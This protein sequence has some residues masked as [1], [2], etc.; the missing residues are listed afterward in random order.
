MDKE[1]SFEFIRETLRSTLFHSKPLAERT[2][3]LNDIAA[4]EGVTKQEL[5]ILINDSLAEQYEQRKQEHEFRDVLPILEQFDYNTFLSFI[6]AGDIKGKDLLALCN[7][8]KKFQNYC[9]QG[10]EVENKDGDVIRIDDQ[11]LFR[12][13]L[14]KMR[15]R[16]R[17]GKTPRETYIER[18]IGGKVW[19]AGQN[20]VGTLGLGDNQRRNVLTPVPIENNIIEISAGENHSLCLDNKGYVWSFGYGME[21]Q[22]GTRLNRSR[23]FPEYIYGLENIVQVS[24]GDRHSLCLDNQGRVWSFGDNG[25][26][27]LGLGE[28]VVG[29]HQDSN[30]PTL[31]PNLNNIIQVSAGGYHSLCLDYQGRVWG[32]GDNR[33]GE[34]GLGDKKKRVLP[35]LI[36][37][38][39]NIIQVSAGGYHSLCLDNQGRVWSF[40]GNS[41]GQLGL[42]D[43]LNRYIP[44][45]IP[46]LSNIVDIYGG[47]AHSLCLDDQGHVWSFGNNADGRLGLGNNENRN[48]PTLILNLN[49]IIKVSGQINNSFCLDNQGK[50]WEFGYNRVG[51]SEL[52]DILN[53]N[54]PTLFPNLNNVFQISGG[55]GYFLVLKF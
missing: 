31:I 15:T 23:N 46:T 36:P 33:Y 41:T 13:L 4:I 49:N 8:S 5:S 32:F 30:V 38:L 14:A 3:Y 52:E 25:Y 45:L 9:N 21:G 28:L 22:L 12:V 6:L 19:S 34:L 17:F 42:G 35:T 54:I 11:Y 24:A 29:N 18:T 51:R 39:T 47:N 2:R 20:T 43:N 10:F 44:T 37:N 48:T 1:E 16:P 53:R 40:G 27:Q 50:V 26:G 7:T 55:D